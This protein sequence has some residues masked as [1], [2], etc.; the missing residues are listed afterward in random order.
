MVEAAIAL[1][2]PI[3][4]TS[5]PALWGQYLRGTVSPLVAFG[6][7]EIE[8]AT[9]EGHASDLVQANLIELLSSVGRICLDFYFLRVRRALEEFQIS[10]ALSALEAARHEGH[11]RF[12]GLGA[13]GHSVGVRSIWQF[14]D[15]FEVLAISREGSNGDPGGLVSLALER[16]VGVLTI[17]DNP[18]MT[19]GPCSLVPV[20]TPSDLMKWEAVSA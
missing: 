1:G 7:Q 6:G 16:R 17:T 14:H 9:S 13:I 5:Q 3:D 10:G 18:T 20:R 15:G 8:R 19:Y 12:L 11:I 2:V 4:I